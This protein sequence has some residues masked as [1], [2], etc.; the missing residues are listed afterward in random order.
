[1]K[2]LLIVA[3][4]FDYPAGAAVKSHRHEEH[5]L[6]YA[7]SGVMN[8]RTG[9]GTWIVP[10][11]RALWVPSRAEHSVRAVSAVQM[12]TLYI[13]PNR[14]IRLPKDC[15]V[16]AAPPLL[17]ALIIH[18]I[19]LTSST[20]RTRCIRVID[21]I[22]DELRTLDVQPLHIAF[23]QTGP[24]AIVCK[25]LAQNPGS[26]ATLER[27]ASDCAVSAKTLARDF[28]NQ[29]GMTFGRWRQQLRLMAA[30]GCAR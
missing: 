3:G 13:R 20:D 1:M 14:R 15:C 4:A 8:V 9:S 29:T 11:H 24:A 7:A 5:Q 26:T 16:V 23:A 27:W 12:R 19:G 28:Q 25:A 2:A 18:L 21:V 10:P 17:R 30:L 22:L 6:V